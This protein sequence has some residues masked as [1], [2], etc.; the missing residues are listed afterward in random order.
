MSNGRIILPYYRTT[1]ANPCLAIPVDGV[2]YKLISLSLSRA[3]LEVVIY[4]YFRKQPIKASLSLN[5]LSRLPIAN[6]RGSASSESSFVPQQYHVRSTYYTCVSIH[7]RIGRLRVGH[8]I[9]PSL[10]ISRAR[11]EALVH[12]FFRKHPIIQFNTRKTEDSL[13]SN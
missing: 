8:G 13:N 9:R 12:D 11:L 10:S 1:R 4:N 3:R 7:R 2:K 5:G 6:K